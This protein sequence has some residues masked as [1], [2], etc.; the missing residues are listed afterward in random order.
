MTTEIQ[1]GSIA[2]KVF[3]AKTNNPITGATMTVGSKSTN[4]DTG[5]NYTLSDIFVGPQNIT[6]SANGYTPSTKSATMIAHGTITVD[7]GITP[8]VCPGPTPICLGGTPVCPGPKPDNIRPGPKPILEQ[9]AN[10]YL[11]MAMPKDIH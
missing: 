7:F 9:E 11:C 4:T 10:I 5:G 8:H 2:G 6:A 3:D 1:V